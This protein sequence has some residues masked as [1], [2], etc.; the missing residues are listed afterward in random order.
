MGF[1]RGKNR[2]RVDAAQRAQALGHAFSR[3][4][5]LFARIAGAAALLSGAYFGARKLHAWATTSERFALDAVT[6]AGTHRASPAELARSAGLVKGVNLFELDLAA[7]KRAIEQHP[8]VR[9]ADVTRHLPSA[10]SVRV[11]EHEPA[12][13]ISLGDLYLVDREGKP[14]KRLQPADALDL[15]LLTGVS[16][17]AYVANPAEAAESFRRAL[18]ALGACAGM[19]KAE[20]I[21]EVHIGARSLTVITASGIEVRLG[22]GASAEKLARLSRVR[23]ELARRGLSAEVI[24]LD[25]RVRPGWV[26]VKLSTSPSERRSGSIP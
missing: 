13:V 17:E 3:V 20:R 8:W 7:A 22:E 10:V 26:A 12:A 18:A 6:F 23:A 4:G 24:H 15:P 14:F 25:N 11:E 2:R 1:G 9:E 5:R 16:R 21:S 19:E